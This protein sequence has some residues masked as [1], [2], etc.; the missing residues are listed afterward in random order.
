[1]TSCAEVD[2]KVHGRLAIAEAVMRSVGNRID[3]YRIDGIQ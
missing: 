3:S 2:H 1:V